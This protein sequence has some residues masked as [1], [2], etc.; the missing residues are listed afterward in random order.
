MQEKLEQLREVRLEAW[1][2][3]ERSKEDRVKKTTEMVKA[4]KPGGKDGKRAGG[5]NGTAKGK[6]RSGEKPMPSWGRA[7]VEM[8]RVIVVREGRL[9]D[10]DYLLT[11]VRCLEVECLLRGLDP[12]KAGGPKGAGGID[13]D[14]LSGVRP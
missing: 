1:L 7:E 10:N 14:A 8:L 5:P 11:I 2:A 12:A 13:W 9:A 3:W 6:Q 4:V